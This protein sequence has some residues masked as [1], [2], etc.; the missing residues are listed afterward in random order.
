MNIYFVNR[1]SRLK[2]PFDIIDTIR[3]HIIKVGDICLRDTTGGVEFLVVHTSNNSWNA[4]KCVGLGNNDDLLNH[5]NTL[6]F[7]F[8][9]IH[10]R[11]GNVTFLNQLLSCFREKVII[12]FFENAVNIL[13]YRCDS[14]DASLFPKFFS[15][16]QELVKIKHIEVTNT[17][18]LHRSY[19]SV[20]SKYLSE[21]L[22]NELKVSINEGN[23][24]KEAY[25]VIRNKHPKLFR[26]A[27]MK[28]LI[29][30]PNGTIFDKEPYDDKFESPQQ[31]VH[32]EI[33]KPE[34]KDLPKDEKANG[35]IHFLLNDYNNKEIKKLIRDYHKGDKKAF[36]KIVIAN[37]KLV[38]AIACAYKDH[39]V[40]YDDL[41]QEGT[42]GLI[43]AVERF[44][45]N[46]NVQ[47]PA[48][49]RWWIHQALIQALI[50]MQSMIKIPSNQVSLYRKIKKSIERYEQ[51]HGYEPSSSDIVIEEEIDP[52]NIAF[53]SNL[54]DN[55]SNLTS[56]KDDWEDYPNYDFIPDDGLEKEDKSNIINTALNGLLGEREMEIVKAVWGV[57]Q[58]EQSLSK[59]AERF[60][61]T[62]ERVRQIAW[63]A[64]SKIKDSSIYKKFLYTDGKLL[65]KQIED[66]KEYKAQ[67]SEIQEGTLLLSEVNNEFHNVG[68]WQRLEVNSS[69]KWDRDLY[70]LP[71]QKKEKK[72]SQE[73][74]DSLGKSLDAKRKDG[75]Q[76][77]KSLNVSNE[78]SEKSIF[79]PDIIYSV[80]KN[81]TSTYKFYWFISI[82][83][84]L[85][86]TK[87]SHL[88]I[89]DVLARMVA[90]A[91]C[92]IT[93]YNINFGSND[94]LRQ[95][96]Y[97]LQKITNLPNYMNLE[98][99]YEGIQ[100]KKDDENI[101][102]EL[103]KLIKYVPFRFLSPWIKASESQEC[104]ALSKE[105]K[106]DC[107][108]A[109]F[110]DNNNPYICINPS[111]EKFLREKNSELINFSYEE[112]AR[113]LKDKN[114]NAK[115]IFKMINAYAS[116]STSPVFNVCLDSHGTNSITITNKGRLCSLC[117]EKGVTL[118]SSSGK[119]IKCNSSYFR[120]VYTYSFFSTNLI[121]QNEHGLICIGERI[122]NAK[123]NSELYNVLEKDIYHEQIEAIR[124][125]D[126]NNCYYIQVDNIWYNNSG[127]C[128]DSEAR[129]ANRPNSFELNTQNEVDIEEKTVVKKDLRIVAYNAGTIAIVGNT[130]PYK[131]EL[132]SY[133]GYFVSSSP[134]GPVWVFREKKRNALQAYIDGT[135]DISKDNRDG[136]AYKKASVS[137]APQAPENMIDKIYSTPLIK[138]KVKVGD[139]IQWKPTRTV[140]KVV[141]F[142]RNGSLQKI[143][144]RTKGGSEMEVYDN[145]KVY[146][147]IHK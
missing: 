10:K 102:I 114:P 136:M 33:K 1:Y 120:L 144:I 94:S 44:N 19:P 78:C 46:R 116:N 95:I 68:K 113:F 127:V 140:G 12:D 134:W 103:Q 112:L 54:P 74:N 41:I 105:Y 66:E 34:I 21:E 93:C 11:K 111:W 81:T 24:L 118:L 57:D 18:T 14:W 91:W 132:K 110:T 40:E 86:K 85:Q 124:Y 87:E 28:F 117:D 3:K 43:R 82:L 107:L 70:K 49:A 59:I 62:R 99:I 119:I 101:K 80:F 104:V 20:F 60:Y 15:P 58:E 72:E 71:P 56:I 6:L 141:G 106:N 22:L 79:T 97:A 125:D 92:P 77:T 142:K 45:P 121:V 76:E 61:L 138:T 39:G 7:S 100:L 42:I 139:W 4:C 135:A 96:V 131:D 26:K 63:K 123:S 48:Y 73:E 67:N 69:R 27:L 17:Q 122:I 88:Y 130:K 64:V 51:E 128:V 50:N 2:G 38:K 84:L 53:L 65:G 83:Q 23:T 32:T 75:V 37:L 98:L 55:L 115:D 25:G 108:Y 133:G 30:N 52:E 143:V 29:E 31:K 137:P 36:D 8:D 90:N 146:V 5:G 126:E 109:L 16:N 9:G 47:F 13:D 129:K 89:Y 145:P 35:Y 147:F